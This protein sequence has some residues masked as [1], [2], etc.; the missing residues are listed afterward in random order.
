MANSWDTQSLRAFKGGS[1]KASGAVMAHRASG[2]RTYRI[3]RNSGSPPYEVNV[4]VVRDGKVVDAGQSVGAL[5][6]ALNPPSVSGGA[7]VIAG[8]SKAQNAAFTPPSGY[9]E[10][11]DSGTSSG[12]G[13]RATVAYNASPSDPEDPAAFGGTSS[14]G[15][16]ASGTVAVAGQASPAD[17][18]A[19]LLSLSPARLWLFDRPEYDGNTIMWQDSAKTTPVAA[20]GDPVG[21]V[22][23]LVTGDT[24]SGVNEGT[25]ADTGHTLLTFGFPA[26]SSL[27]VSLS[28]TVTPELLAAVYRPINGTNMSGDV[29]ISSS[30]TRTIAGM[31]SAGYLQ[32]AWRERQYARWDVSESERGYIVDGGDLVTYSYA[33]PPDVDTMTIQN[34]YWGAIAL[35]ETLPADLDYIDFLFSLLGDGA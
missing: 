34:G 17:P 21:A 33:A 35:W 25:Y 12:S 6:G 16:G 2:G 7:L 20:N 19:E 1:S 8:A 29:G 3:E 14:G 10:L 11:R 28:A 31:S 9:T 23:C 5:P 30:T 13:V 18:V 22:E 27:T 26:S 32:T 24:F 15:P 4:V